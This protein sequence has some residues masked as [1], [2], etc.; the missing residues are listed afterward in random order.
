MEKQQNNL[1]WFT[2]IYIY[3]RVYRIYVIGYYIFMYTVW[4]KNNGVKS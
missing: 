1:S 2:D 3:T 4:G